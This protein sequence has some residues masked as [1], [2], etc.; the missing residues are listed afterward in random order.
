MFTVIFLFALAF[1]AGVSA[2]ESRRP[3]SPIPK[4]ASLAI[5]VVF[6]LLFFGYTVGK[7]MAKRDSG[8]EAA[9]SQS[10]SK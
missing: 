2:Q 4:Y 1:L 5:A 7:D 10:Q 3:Q 6:T 8:V 9:T